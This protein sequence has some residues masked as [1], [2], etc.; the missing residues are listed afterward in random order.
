MKFRTITSN[1][2]ECEFYRYKDNKC[3]IGYD[4]GDFDNHDECTDYEPQFGS[5]DWYDEQEEE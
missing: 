2:R 5:F 1:C 4:V 3:E